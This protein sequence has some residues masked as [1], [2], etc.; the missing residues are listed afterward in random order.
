M[1]NFKYLNAFMTDLKIQT[2]SNYFYSIEI[3][4]LRNKPIY[5]I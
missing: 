4:I 3:I 2:I 5:V 1:F